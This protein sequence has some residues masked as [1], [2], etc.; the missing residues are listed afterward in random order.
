MLIA[1]FI[2]LILL[3]L[4]FL[5]LDEAKFGKPAGGE[6][7]ERIKASPHFKDGQF[8]NLSETPQLTEGAT[9][10]SVMRE[11]FFGKNKNGTPATVLPSKKT[12]LLNLHPAQ[13]VLVW[14][15]HS[16][17]F[18]Q[19]DGKKI[20]V[21]PVLSGSA[22]PIKFTTKSFKGSDVYT[23]DDIPHID[24][25]FISHD[26]WDHL[27]HET[28][29]KLKPKI[30]KVI[31]GLG[32]GAHLEHWGYE[33][34]KIIEKDWNEE[35]ILEDGFKVYTTPA[36]HFS[37]RSLK[38]N[39]ALWVSFV[40][41]TPSLKI[42]LGGDSGYDTHFKEIGKTFGPFDLVILENGQYNKNWKH[43]HMMP[44]EVVQAAQDL[45]AKALLP[46][47]WSKFSLAIHA[48]DEPIQRVVAEAN[49][50][51][52]KILHPMIGEALNLN[53]PATTT[54]WWEGNA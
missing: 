39:R 7:L 5:F 36:R 10:L 22:S 12:D 23:T 46:V 45:D 40:L 32:T 17:Y 9:Y 27:D 19:I 8:H 20:L 33:P 1:L 31:T 24:Y 26:H 4:L 35:I 44:E 28:V 6:R 48:W 16:S 54:R 34:K 13:N 50:K 25:L 29:V 53:D 2:F 15:G 18:L 49:K 41:A 38:R 30:G 37:G 11:F 14:F 51:Q 3:A 43:I 47:H 52:M 42:F 21:D